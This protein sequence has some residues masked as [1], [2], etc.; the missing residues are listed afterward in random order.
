[1]KIGKH[2]KLDGTYD[3][4]QLKPGKWYLAHTDFGWQLGKFR[5]EWFGRCLEV[6]VLDDIDDLYEVTL[7]KLRKQP[8]QSSIVKKQRKKDGVCLQCGHKGTLDS[9]TPG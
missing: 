1:M 3:N 6:P 9:P 4:K 5:K 2:I 8:T 7:S